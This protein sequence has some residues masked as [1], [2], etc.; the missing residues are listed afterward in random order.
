SRKLIPEEVWELVTFS[1]VRS[2]PTLPFIGDMF[3]YLSPAKTILP[4]KK[5]VKKPYFKPYFSKDR[6]A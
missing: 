5:N 3:K 6:V 2:K 4:L 1:L